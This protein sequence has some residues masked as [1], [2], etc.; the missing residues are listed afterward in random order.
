MDRVIGTKTTGAVIMDD[1]TPYE[2]DT[3]TT[4]GTTYMRYENTALAQYNKR[5]N[6]TKN[7]STIALWSNR[8]SAT[9]N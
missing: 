7:E 4:A 2:V 5:W 8:A 6:G 9:Y 3:T 1:S